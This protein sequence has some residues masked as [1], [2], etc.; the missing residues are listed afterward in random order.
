MKVFQIIILFMLIIF[1][2]CT[3][4]KKEVQ[5]KP[6]L[7]EDEVKIENPEELIEMNVQ[8]EIGQSELFFISNLIHKFPTQ[9][10]LFSNEILLNRLKNIDR[11]NAESL[12]ANWNTETPITIEDGIIHSSGC[13]DNDCPSNAYELFI[14]LKGDNINIY[15]FKGN[16]LRIYKEKELIDL[17][18]RYK[19]ELEIKKTNAKIGSINESISEYKLEPQS[20]SPNNSNTE[21]ADQIRTYLNT[22]LLK[23]DI[24][25][26]TE[27]QRYFQYEQVDLND[28][29]IFEYLIGFQNSYF[30]GTGGCTFMLINNDGSLITK[31][32]VSE[33]PFIVSNAKSNGY[34]DLIVS[35]K[36]KLHFL[37]YNGKTYPKNPSVAPD[38]NE[39]PGDDLIRL[40]WEEFPIPTFE[41]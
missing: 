40:L 14:D 36:G 19:E 20:Y 2:N 11:F 4:S 18:K 32:S 38:Y 28:D 39:I 29:G 17:P 22:N 23:E 26:L 6:I 8:G 12:V 10:D 31:F 34:K 1:Y 16:M 27:D 7:S 21:V 25:V 13:Q 33:T 15:N 3:S 35:S 5:P 9:V 30:C 41:F 24:K 37:Q